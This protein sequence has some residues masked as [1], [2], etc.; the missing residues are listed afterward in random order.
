M[1]LRIANFGR[2]YLFLLI[3][4]G[5][6][7]AAISMIVNHESYEIGKSW[8]EFEH[9]R[10]EKFRALAILNQTLGYGGMVH[11]FKN[12]VIRQQAGDKKQADIQLGAAFRSV[13]NFENL[14]PTADE[15]A[16][17]S[18]IIHILNEYYDKLQIAER[19][20]AQGTSPTILDQLIAIDDGRAIEAIKTLFNLV[21]D[22]EFVNHSEMVSYSEQLIE[23][24]RVIGYGGMIHNFKNY[25]LRGDI[26][27]K[28]SAEKSIEN[29]H[30]LLLLYQTDTAFQEE[31]EATLVILGTVD[32][33]SKNLDIITAMRASG[34][35]IR[36]IDAMVNV[37]D[38][39]ALDGF[40]ML[41]RSISKR[42][43]G[44]AEEVSHVLG[45]I[46]MMTSQQLKIVT[47]TFLLLIVGSV[48]LIWFRVTKPLGVL[49]EVIGRFVAGDFNVKIP[50]VNAKDEIGQIASMLNLYKKKSIEIA[51]AERKI[52]ATHKRYANILEIATD[53]IIS[54]NSMHEIITFNHGAEVCFGYKASEVIGENV[55][56]LI[57]EEFHHNHSKE[58][59]GFAHGNDKSRLMASRS[60]ILGRK[61]QGDTFLGEGTISKIVEDG[62][63]Y[64]T[65]ILR[66]MTDR[67]AREE[68]LE[69][70][71]VAAELANRSKSAFLANMSHE[72][73]T[74]LNAI[75]GFSSIMM[76]PSITH[77]DEK[78]YLEYS[79]DINDSGQ[80]LLGL[81]CDLL[82]LSKIEAGK[83]ELNEQQV[84]PLVLIQSSINFIKVRADD[85]NI[86]VIVE[87]SG[88]DTEIDADARMLKQMLAN[89]LSNA[90]KFTPSGGK[91]TVGH[92][93]C[94]DGSYS[95]KVTDT[96][97]G[98][99]R[100]HIN[101]VTDA[102]WQ[103]DS[104]HQRSNEGTGL[105]LP[106]VK[107]LIELH[108]GTMVIQ[109]EVDAGTTVELIF[110]AERV[111]KELPLQSNV[112]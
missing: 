1:K 85:E 109:S 3:A 43:N 36:E 103:A 54:I 96:G 35:S 26:A 101:A 56:I 49:S 91:I 5:L 40:T 33:Y 20:I 70:A 63:M 13:K 34:N 99:S 75:I 66:D 90:V 7:F 21:S 74:P 82:D 108:G 2:I 19:E 78:K 18:E 68:E 44:N 17:L 41:S 24:S 45:E 46:A 6:A 14:L 111:A 107:S 106:L 53:S 81:I 100:E 86:D 83:V 87:E 51:R 57:P 94:A 48:Y 67:I 37:D 25:L 11:H 88:L 55:N 84:D 12:Y 59:D 15:N 22:H 10:S 39:A 16:P 9:E 58:I 65:I 105:G 112:I 104:K 76:E 38:R 80:H 28:I 89:L 97:I 98:I 52:K 92:G 30:S 102:F 27:D 4:T 32:K 29:I 79:K 93:L 69:N 42:I 95:I 110:P 71:M 8:N 61:K 77:H 31:R 72:L 62:E 23:L 73:R 64:L 50:G 47:V 60:S